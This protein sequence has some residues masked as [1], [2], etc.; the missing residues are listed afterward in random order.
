MLS[1]CKIAINQIKSNIE[2]DSHIAA[3]LKDIQDLI[4]GFKQYI[5][6]FV[7]RSTNVGSH[8]LAHIAIKLVNDIGWENNFPVG[9]VEVANYDWRA[10]TPF[11]N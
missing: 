3:I 4:K 9:L 6:S 2:Q 5:V 10:E 7:T 11:C 1:K 8:K